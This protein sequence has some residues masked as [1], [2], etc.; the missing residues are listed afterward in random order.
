MSIQVNPG[1][2]EV[3]SSD[4]LQCAGDLLL[5]NKEHAELLQ[6]YDQRA[7]AAVRFIQAVRPGLKVQT[8]A[9]RDPKVTGTYL[10]GS[11]GCVQGHISCLQS[12]VTFH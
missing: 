5:K 7:E 9:L 11:F 12:Y 3:A 10:E 4:C 2:S 6:L 8:A 1:Q